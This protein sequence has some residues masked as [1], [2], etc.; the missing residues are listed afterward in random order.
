MRMRDCP[1]CLGSGYYLEQF[2]PMKRPERKGCWSCAGLLPPSDWR[3]MSDSTKDTK[4]ESGA[5]TTGCCALRDDQRCRLRGTSLE[6]N[7]WYPG[8]KGPG[9]ISEVRVGIVDT[10]AAD[11]IVVRYDFDRDG[12]VV[13]QERSVEDGYGGID[14]T[15][16][17]VER[18]F[19]P[20]W[21]TDE[22]R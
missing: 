6:V 22:S 15:G 2:D 17:M 10:R 12:Y 8:V 20:A 13:L 4:A 11:D 9:T 1:I 19:V 7:M 14:G 21:L 18:A 16:E 5:V 3:D